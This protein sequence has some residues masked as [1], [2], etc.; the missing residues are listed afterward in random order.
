MAL[1]P[2]ASLAIRSTPYCGDESSHQNTSLAST[3]VPT[4][5]AA[6]YPDEQ[7]RDDHVALAPG[8][9]QRVASVSVAA[10]LVD[11]LPRAVSEQQHHGAQVLLRRRPQQL[12]AQGQLGAGRQ[13]RHEHALLVL[14]PDP[15]LAL[16]P[17]DGRKSA[18]AFKI[19]LPV[20]AS[21]KTNTGME[22]CRVYCPVPVYYSDR[23]ERHETTAHSP[24]TKA[25][26]GS[27]GNVRPL[28]PGN[29]Y[30]TLELELLRTRM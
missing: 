5:R 30:L 9:V 19:R 15:T 2:W 12:L 26:R 25:C 28:D 16:L 8:E 3:S 6:P 17:E 1:F 11:L 20:Y 10:R 14:G 24:Q 13:R 29:T 27:G 7:L 23:V 18:R 22:L 4:S 21:Q